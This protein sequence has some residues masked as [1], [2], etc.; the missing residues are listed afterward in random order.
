MLRLLNRKQTTLIT[1]L[2]LWSLVLAP[3]VASAERSPQGTSDPLLRKE[4]VKIDEKGA[5]YIASVEWRFE[6]DDTS[7][8]TDMNDKTMSVSEIPVPC[9]AEIEYRLQMDNAPLLLSLK[10]KRSLPDAHT[11]VWR[12]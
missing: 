9:I 12:R 3:M 4:E 5:D 11:D 10:I 6:L 8:L 1:A 2:L 7:V